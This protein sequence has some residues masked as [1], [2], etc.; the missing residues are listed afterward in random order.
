MSP[1]S[2]CFAFNFRSNVHMTGNKSFP[3]QKTIAIN[4]NLVLCFRFTFFSW[5]DTSVELAEVQIYSTRLYMMV[6][7]TDLGVGGINSFSAV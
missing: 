6:L 4:S 3:L 7:L 5:R 1:T 2:V